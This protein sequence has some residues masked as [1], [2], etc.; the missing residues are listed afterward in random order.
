M[1]ETWVGVLILMSK[2]GTHW[3]TVKLATL[4]VVAIG[5]I[6][7]CIVQEDVRSYGRSVSFNSWAFAASQKRSSSSSVE[8]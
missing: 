1:L 7:T 8:L 4:S 3:I 5:T 6:E 2:R